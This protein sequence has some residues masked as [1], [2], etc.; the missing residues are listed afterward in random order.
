[1]KIFVARCSYQDRKLGPG[2]GR[3][4]TVTA[5]SAPGAIGKAAREFWK[6]LTTRQRNDAL[7]GGMEVRIVERKE[8]EQEKT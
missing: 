3:T 6:S 2:C 1:V 7:R 4:L 8:C 5:T